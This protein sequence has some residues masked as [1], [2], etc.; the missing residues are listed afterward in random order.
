ML[1]QD[2]ESSALCYSVFW[3]D[4]LCFGEDPQQSS[5]IN[6]DLYEGFQSNSDHRREFFTVSRNPS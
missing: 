3:Q 2:L 4:Q 5:K 1:S 6:H